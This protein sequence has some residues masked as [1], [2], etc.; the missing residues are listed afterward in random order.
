MNVTLQDLLN[1]D[2]S[3]THLT[4]SRIHEKHS[5]YNDYSKKGR[6]KNLIF[7]LIEGSMEYKDKNNK[8]LFSIK[9][10]DVVFVADQANYISQTLEPN[11]HMKG[12]VLCFNLKNQQ[13]ETLHVVDTFS[14]LT[15]DYDGKLYKKI[16]TL[17]RRILEN[18]CALSIKSVFYE[19]L[20]LL[21]ISTKKDGQETR[22][23]IL[24]A[25][26]FIEMHPEQN[27]TVKE[28][29][30]MC[31]M[32]ESSFSHKF[33]KHTNGI[34]PIQMRNQIRIIKAEEMANDANLSIEEIADTLGFYDASYLCRLYKKQ[35]G[36]T[37]KKRSR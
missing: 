4:A 16:T 7:Y 3:V 36:N 25:L 6:Y 35:T 26:E 10:G 12:I 24:P 5:S 33:V 19:L 32:S 1:V 8:K 20:Y 28:L 15:N 11:A 27:L 30:N 23:E 34:T 29:A 13:R 31:Q 37:L 9:N 21:L 18:Q 17:S 2:Y 22:K 14:V